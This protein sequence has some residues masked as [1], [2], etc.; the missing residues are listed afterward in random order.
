M[1]TKTKPKEGAVIVLG[2][3]FGTTYAPPRFSFI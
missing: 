3:D 1:A 2:I